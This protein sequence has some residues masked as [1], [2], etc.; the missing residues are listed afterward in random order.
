LK[1]PGTDRAAGLISQQSVWANG[2]ITVVFHNGGLACQKSKKERHEGWPS[3]VHDIALANQGPKFN[4]RRASK[5]GKR[6]GAVV[7]CP[8]STLGDNGDLKIRIGVI[9]HLN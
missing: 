6:E 9:A 8:N 5:D 1:V 4:E 2:L 3:D 7:S